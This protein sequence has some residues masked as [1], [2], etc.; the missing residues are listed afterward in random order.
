[1]SARVPIVQVKNVTHRFGVGDLEKVV[2]QNVTADF[3][4]G[5]IGI[6]MGPS[7]S[8]KTTFLSLLGALRSLQGGSIQFRGKNLAGLNHRELEG[9]RREIGFIF[10]SHHLI[11]SISACENV[12][13]PLYLADGE[14]AA[15]SRARALELLELV[16]LK[17]H[18]HKTP[19]Q[20][21]GGQCQRV[22]IARALVR[23]PGLVLADEP[24][25]S[26][27][28]DNGRA[29]LEA[30]QTLARQSKTT[31]LIVTHDHRILDIADRV[32]LME[33]GQLEEL[34]GRLKILLLEVSAF[35]ATISQKLPGNQLANPTS[36]ETS[37]SDLELRLN[38]LSHLK[39]RTESTL[40]IDL[41]Q[42]MLASIRLLA[43]SVT[44][45]ARLAC[46]PPPGL[47]QLCD[48]FVQALDTILLTAE[49][50]FKEGDRSD[51]QALLAMTGDRKETMARLR[52]SYFEMLVG[53]NEEQKVFL[54]ELTNTFARAVYLLNTLAQ[55]LEKWPQVAAG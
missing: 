38:N 39:T 30:L 2:L 12:Q 17:E 4:E 8:G 26:L 36:F 19:R 34:A 50:A 24:T 54:F 21:S 16:G 11:A 35:F 9:V 43:D 7:G 53:V 28:R 37:I 41:L 44:Q 47:D 51:Q 29:V 52:E 45:F 14:T 31:I 25:A 18:A 3:F 1:M 46:Q 27:D 40:Q 23:R 33:D 5:E 32:M 13:M 49:S 42:Q 55:L 20:L 15:T 48:R 6:I 22:A 10:Q